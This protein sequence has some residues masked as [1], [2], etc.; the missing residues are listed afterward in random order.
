M[1]FEAAQ[2]RMLIKCSTMESTD[3]NSQSSKLNDHETASQS[4]HLITNLGYWDSSRV[5][6][7]M[8][9]LTG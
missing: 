3:G 8:H 9:R 6:A 1:E 2:C 4:A 7:E 5:L